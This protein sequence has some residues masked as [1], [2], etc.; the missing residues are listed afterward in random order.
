MRYIIYHLNENS[1][2]LHFLEQIALALVM[3]LPHTALLLSRN[4]I[5]SFTFLKKKK[6]FAFR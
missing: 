5:L 2:V 3:L 4:V 6:M 1:F